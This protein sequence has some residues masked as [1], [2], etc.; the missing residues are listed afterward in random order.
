MRTELLAALAKA[1]IFPDQLSDVELVKKVSAW[2]FNG[3]AFQFQ[4][5][6][7]S[8]DVEFLNGVATVIPELQD[9]FDSEKAKNNF[10]DD[11]EALA[12]GIYG[13]AMFRSRKFGN[14]TYW[15]R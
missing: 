1:N 13:K 10:T 9:H 2:I 12:Q 14:C 11:S 3:Q 5:H 7:I 6:F 8:Y 4:D 15:L